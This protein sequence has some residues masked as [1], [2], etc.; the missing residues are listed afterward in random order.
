[1]NMRAQ[2]SM[3][4]ILGS[5]S[6]TLILTLSACSSGT[7][8]L[9][10]WTAQEKAKRGAP[11]DPLPVIKTFENFEYKDQDLRDP[12]SPSI[13]EQQQAQAVTQAGLHPD[14][15]A[16]EALEGFPLDALKMMGTLGSGAQMEGLIK[17]PDGVIHRVHARNYMGQNNG[18]I[19]SIAEDHI[20][21][22]ELLPN[23]VGGW[24]EHPVALAMDE[25]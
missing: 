9:E 19:N 13:E 5:A 8:D 1:M 7:V 10:Q 14:D 21:L 18:R 24:M 22:V 12:F 2:Q 4:F 23:G 6:L 3:K 11:L 17:D 20:D 25:K 15:H 16:H